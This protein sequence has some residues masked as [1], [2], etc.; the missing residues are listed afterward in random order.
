MRAPAEAVLL[1]LLEL[2]IALD[3]VLGE[4]SAFEQPHTLGDCLTGAATQAG[5]DAGLISTDSR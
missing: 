3:L 1:F 5:R 4:H 2:E